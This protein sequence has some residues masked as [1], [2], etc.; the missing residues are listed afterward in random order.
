MKIVRERTVAV[1]AAVEKIGCASQALACP[2]GGLL[3]QLPLQLPRLPLLAPGI[4][5]QQLLPGG[6]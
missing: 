3:P 1:N 2:A 5:K 4:L 6:R